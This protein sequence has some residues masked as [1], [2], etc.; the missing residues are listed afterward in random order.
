MSWL[1]SP[2]GIV[3]AV[4]LSVGLL[5]LVVQLVQW[6]FRVA[7]RLKLLEVKDAQLAEQLASLR[8]A[9]SLHDELSQLLGKTINSRLDAL[10]ADELTLLDQ[11]IRQRL[12]ELVAPVLQNASPRFSSAFAAAVEEQT[13]AHLPAALAAA[14]PRIGAALE[15]RLQVALADADSDVWEQI[16]DRLGRRLVAL[17]ETLPAE[18]LA[19]LDARAGAAL[20]GRAVEML[21]SPDDFTDLFERIDAA[22]Q[23]QILGTVEEPPEECVQAIAARTAAG[24]AARVADIFDNPG[25]HD[26]LF[27]RLDEKLGERILAAADD[28][29]DETARQLDERICAD[30]VDEINHICDNPGEHTELYENLDEKLGGRMLELAGDPPPEVEQ[31]LAERLEAGLLAEVDHLFE[32]R[33]EQEEL[34]ADLDEK[35]GQHLRRRLRDELSSGR[36]GRVEA[37][38]DE[39]LRAHVRAR[40][41][42]ADLTELDRLLDQRLAALAANAPETAA[43]I[44]ERL[45]E[46]L[47]ARA[48]NRAAGSDPGPARPL[49]QCVEEWVG[50]ALEQAR[51]AL[52]QA[53][54][55][56]LGRAAEPPEGGEAD[57][58]P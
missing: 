52:Q 7:L 53:L 35:L 15:Q 17:A 12:P 45:R 14:G 11:A 9:R 28:P 30:L 33:D 48:A 54:E 4:V 44:D 1:E 32:N 37:A 22:L 46:E 58:G 5:Y 40:L 18:A 3:V 29:P 43:R 21:A 49:T 20:L 19:R 36:G 56:W 34:F 23:E 8:P 55:S 41:E 16:D 24:M 47:A 13:L 27:E 26:D 10:G 38:L 39:R 25:D 57:K 42:A 50:A 6:H 51:P 2:S 31:R